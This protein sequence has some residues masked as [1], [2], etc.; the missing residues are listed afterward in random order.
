[1]SEPRTWL[2]RLHLDPVTGYYIDQGA[3]W[4]RI[5]REQFAGA[6]LARYT[7]MDTTTDPE[8]L[9]GAVKAYVDR[10]VTDL[11]NATEIFELR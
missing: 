11:P 9:A 6:C 10:A 1:V 2:D 4:L 5:S 7:S 3:A 8:I